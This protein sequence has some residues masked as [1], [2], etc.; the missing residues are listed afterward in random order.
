MSADYSKK[1]NV[2]LEELLKSRSLPHTGKK[3]DLVARLQEYDAKQAST[4]STAR[5]LAATTA[6]A[7]TTPSKPSTTATTVAL[8]DEID[9]EE[10]DNSVATPAIADTTNATAT[11][12][13][14]RSKASSTKVSTSAPSSGSA[15]GA[16]GLGHIS[17]S[18][19][20]PNQPAAVD[21]AQTK[22]LTVHL[23]KPTTIDPSKTKD[24][25]VH[26]PTQLTISTTTEKQA[27]PPRTNF[28]SNL[29]TT[30]VEDELER[31]AK[32]AARFGTGAVDSVSEPA[33]AEVANGDTPVAAAETATKAPMTSATKASAEADARKALERAKKFGTGDGVVKGLDEALPE[34]GIK[35]GRNGGE[36]GGRGGKRGRRGDFH[37][38]GAKR[39]EG[40]G[41][42]RDVANRREG[43]GGKER[44]GRRNGGAAGGKGE[45]ATLSQKD[46]AA[47]EARKKKFAAKA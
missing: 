45:M 38:G 44:G 41:G 9:W 32:R 18:T 3:A 17:N 8:E 46:R 31:R 20:I 36:D 39:D 33:K 42:Q 30:T 19:A 21:P 1:K 12:D 14:P 35:R 4:S 29:P 23:P 16:G 28:A 37:N 5:K 34:R 7:A 11:T 6:A 47:A 22:D 10:D 2:E 26:P 24:L 25:T 40:A 43:G 27:A 13:A 15:L